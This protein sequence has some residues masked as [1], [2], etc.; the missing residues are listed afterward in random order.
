MLT[1]AKPAKRPE[2][3]RQAEQRVKRWAEAAI[4]AEFAGEIVM[5]AE[6]LCNKPECPLE[7]TITV[8]IPKPKVLKV[9]KPIVEVTQQEVVSLSQGWEDMM[10]R[11]KPVQAWAEEALPPD[12]A[13]CSVVVEET[14]DDNP[15]LPFETV[16]TVL[17][18]PKHRTMKVLK[19]LSEVTQDDVQRLMAISQFN[20]DGIA[21]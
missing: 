9:P 12:V 15:T 7:T 5:V 11:S 17:S 1:F 10:K 21:S 14:E 16:I 8:L 20:P 2:E 6:I 4:P 13:G 19:P 3:A 18:S